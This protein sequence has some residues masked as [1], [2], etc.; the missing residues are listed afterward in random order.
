MLKEIDRKIIE[1]NGIFQS[2]RPVKFAVGNI[3]SSILLGQSFDHGDRK[4]FGVPR[5]N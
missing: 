4:I 5:N 2:L 1:N 3:I